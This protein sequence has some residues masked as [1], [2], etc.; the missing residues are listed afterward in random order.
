MAKDVKAPPELE[1]AADVV[2]D[3]NMTTRKATELLKYL[4]FTRAIERAGGNQGTAARK[5]GMT[6]QHLNQSLA[7]LESRLA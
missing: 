1:T 2:L 4:M 6:R 3:H 7:L 5:L